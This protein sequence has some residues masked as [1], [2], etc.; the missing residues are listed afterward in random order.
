MWMEFGCKCRSNEQWSRHWNSPKWPNTGV[1][2][3]ALETRCVS[4]FVL[5]D[6]ET[7]M[8][9]PII[10]WHKQE[11]R[12]AAWLQPP[13]FA[14]QNKS[15]TLFSSYNFNMGRVENRFSEFQFLIVQ[16]LNDKIILTIT[17]QQ[18]EKITLIMVN[19]IH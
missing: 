16:M 12:E 11:L 7:Y 9:F 14:P 18:I 6:W 1:F 4:C 13:K 8:L 19:W 10:R 2:F 17:K 5:L 3:N 15:V